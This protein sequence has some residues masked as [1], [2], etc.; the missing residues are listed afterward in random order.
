MGP[1]SPLL[2]QVPGSQPELWLL[3]L[4]RFSW[5]L[6]S[7]LTLT[8][9]MPWQLTLRC[10]LESGSIRPSHQCLFYLVSP[11]LSWIFSSFDAHFAL[12]QVFLQGEGEGKLMNTYS[13]ISVL[14]CWNNNNIRL[15]REKKEWKH[16]TK[17]IHKLVKEKGIIL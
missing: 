15:K 6:P 9:A 14:D 17:V 13:N 12:R 2:A 4:A 5:L 11:S 3:A 10:T 7:R 8:P 16:P 1:D